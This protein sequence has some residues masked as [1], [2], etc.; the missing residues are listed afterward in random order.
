MSLSKQLTLGV[1]CILLLMFLGT[2]FTNISNTRDYISQQLSSHAQDTATSLGM[3]IMPYMTNKD[4]IVIA[5]TMVQAI[6]DR[7]FYASIAVVDANDQTVISFENTKR[8]QDIPHYFVEIFEI[9]APLMS[10]EITDAWVR[11]GIV[12]VRSNTGLAYQQLW[13]NALNHL[14]LSTGVFIVTLL[15]IWLLV[16]YLI[17]QPINTLIQQTEEI[18]Q[19]HFIQI[20][21]APRTTELRRFVKAVNVM[22]AK[23]A[24]LFTQMAQQSEKYRLFAY[25]D[26]LT[27]VGNRRSFELYIDQTLRNEADRPSGYLLLINATSLSQVHKHLGGELGDKYLQAIC[28]LSKSITSQTHQ[29]FSIYRING[30]D[31]ALVLENIDASKAILLAKQLS[32]GFKQHE[33][34]EYKLGFAHIGM[35]SFKYADTLANIMQRADSALAVAQDNSQRWE[36]SD[37]IAVTHSNEQ[38]REKIQNTLRAQDVGFAQQVIVDSNHELIYAECFARIKEH[39]DNHVGANEKDD[40]IPMNQLIPASIR[41]DHAVDL[42]RMIVQSFLKNLANSPH[43]IAVNLSRMSL[44]D[45][46]FTHWLTNQLT[47]LSQHCH[48][49]I[50][51]IPERAL[52]HDTDVLCPTIETLRTL[53]A[54]IV[55]E[56]Y[57]AQLAGIQHLQRLRPDYLKIDGRFTKNIN[58][59]IDNQLFLQ[60]LVHI[61]HGLQIKVIAE[62]IETDEELAW[63]KSA[64]VDYFQGYQIA[65]P[66]LTE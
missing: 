26:P 28:H 13:S 35:T 18:S 29:H 34:T 21:K 58:T 25:T 51:E 19:Q 8:P 62:M 55:V 27:K 41:L 10:S 16:K 42:D 14:Y 57:G 23:L 54:K 43:Q 46:E 12:K 45:E 7:G 38:W 2:L 47:N 33:K 52:V 49:L 17:S 64:N 24:K 63:L 44:F 1:F 37:N 31:F 3:S 40:C 53:G 39:Q 56:H 4:D 36:L 60:S 32:Q 50:I 30:G 48:K 20:E 15:S 61:A 5:D 66:T 22:S 11:S 65:A 59:E 9:N 6:F